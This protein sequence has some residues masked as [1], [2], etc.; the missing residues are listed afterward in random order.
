M[1]PSVVRLAS[2]WRLKDLACFDVFATFE[3][4]LLKIVTSYLTCGGLLKVDSFS[5]LFVTTSCFM[6][7]DDEYNHW[8]AKRKEKLI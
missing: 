3:I 6:K 1:L 7:A 4:F 8:P 2:M 5:F